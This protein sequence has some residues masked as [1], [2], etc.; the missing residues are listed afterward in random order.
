VQN[1]LEKGVIEPAVV[2][3]QAMK[4]AAESATMILRIDDVIAA[5]KSKEGGPPGGPGGPPGGY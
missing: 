3:E 2:K 5:T 1:S 4:S